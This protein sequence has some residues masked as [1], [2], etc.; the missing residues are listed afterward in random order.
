MARD[1]QVVPPFF[2]IMEGTCVFFLRE[3]TITYHF[4]GGMEVL[5]F[6]IQH[7]DRP[8]ARLHEKGETSTRYN[9]SLNSYVK[10]CKNQRAPTYLKYCIHTTVHITI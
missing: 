8:N 2:R 4:I 10:E 5:Q 1:G 7:R 3:I 6:R 9:L